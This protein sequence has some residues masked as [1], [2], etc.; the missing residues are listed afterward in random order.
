MRSQAA[1]QTQG[2]KFFENTLGLLLGALESDKCGQP[3]GRS[4]VGVESKVCN[5]LNL[6]LNLVKA[7]SNE[8]K[9]VLSARSTGAVT[10]S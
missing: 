3:D 9:N 8:A 10:L 2:W 6:A 7:S 4:S 1:N 5:N